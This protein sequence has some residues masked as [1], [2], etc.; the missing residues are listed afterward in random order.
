VEKRKKNPL[1]AWDDLRAMAE[2]KQY[3]KGFGVSQAKFHGL[4]YVAPNQSSYMCRLRLAAGILST[5]QFRGVADIAERF[6]RRLHPRDDP[7]QLADPGDPGRDSLALLMAL[8]DFG[9]VARGTA[10]TTSGT[11]RPPRRRAS[12]RRS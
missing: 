7:G 5:W 3:P 4:F 6:G 9:I 10:P 11:S 1:D 12:T 2:K 8:Q